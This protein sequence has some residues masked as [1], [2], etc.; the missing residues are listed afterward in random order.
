MTSTTETVDVLIAAWN[1]SDTIARAILSGLEHP[2]VRTV[3]VVDDGSTDD[4]AEVAAR[5]AADSGRVAVCSLPVNR[6]PS[7]ARN[8]AIEMSS[9]QWISIL[10]GDD[11]FLPGRIARMLSLAQDYD[12]VADDILQ[13]RRGE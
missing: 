11:Y 3:I 7:A 2:E 5:V 4:T 12:L 6:G 9:A 8:R 10:D 1:R 13:E